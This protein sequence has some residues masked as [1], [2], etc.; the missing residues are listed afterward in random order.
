MKGMLKTNEKS[1]N[2]SQ[3]FESSKDT[4]GLSDLHREKIIFDNEIYP[5]KHAMEEAIK[6]KEIEKSRK[7]ALRDQLFAR[8]S[9][10]IVK[11]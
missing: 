1:S 6:Q 7:P 5:Q 8:L 4:Q 3:L 9:S 11:Q 10:K 2:V